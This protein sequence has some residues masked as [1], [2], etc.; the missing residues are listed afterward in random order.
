MGSRRSRPTTVR[1]RAVHGER[2][3]RMAPHRYAAPAVTYTVEARSTGRSRLKVEPDTFPGV[4][5]IL[6]LGDTSITVR[7]SPDEAAHL[8]AGLAAAAEGC[9]DARLEVSA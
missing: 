9:A 8:A 2:S 3:G 6:P 4:R 7:L 1:A 5:L